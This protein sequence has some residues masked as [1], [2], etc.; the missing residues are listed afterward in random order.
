MSLGWTASTDNV[1]GHRATGSSAARAAG[2]TT[3]AAGR[4]ADRHDLQRH[5]RCG[6]D[7]VPL[8]RRAPSTRPA[9]SARYSDIAAATTGAPRRA[10][11]GPGGGVGVRRGVGLDDRRM[12]RG[13]GTPARS[14]ARRGP[15][16]PVRQRAELQRHQQPSCGCR[17]GVAGADGGDDAVGVGQPDRGQSGW[18]TI[19]QRQTDAYFLN[20]SNDAGAL[21]PV[22]RRHVRRRL[23]CVD[24]PDGQPGERVDAR[25]GDLRRRDAAALRQRHAGGDRGRDRRD[26]E[27]HEPAVDRRQPARTA[28]TSTGLID[29]VRVYNRALT[30]SEINRTWATR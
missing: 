6:V 30:P 16:G 21:R 14:P 19:M 25:G 2:C 13:T 15:R 5:R 18:R 4:D 29:E 24:G 7:D 1:G 11:A 12:R 26:P 27:P 23:T 20:A 9:T 17:L 22:G 8:P 3:F 10:P 28:S